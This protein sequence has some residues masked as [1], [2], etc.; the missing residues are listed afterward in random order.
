MWTE[1]TDLDYCQQD[2]SVVLKEAL[3]EDFVSTPVF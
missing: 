2:S 3:C 1:P